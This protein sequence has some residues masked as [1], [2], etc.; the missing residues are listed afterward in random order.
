[1]PQQVIAYIHM[2]IYVC[3]YIIYIYIYVYIYSYIYTHVYVYM[4]I[5]LYIHR[6]ICIYV[7]VYIQQ[8]V[9]LEGEDIIDVFV[10]NGCEHTTV[11]A[12]D[13]KLYTCG[14]NYRGQLGMYLLLFIDIVSVCL[15]WLL[16]FFL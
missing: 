9:A 3:K 11:T 5:F 6:Y 4:Y 7:Y 14:Y 15:L 1:L 10:F 13:G 8:V 12:R 16:P 2:C